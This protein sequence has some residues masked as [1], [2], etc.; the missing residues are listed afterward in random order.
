MSGIDFLAWRL[1]YQSDEHALRAAFASVNNLA[2]QLERA[3]AQLLAIATAKRSNFEDSVEYQDWAAS[4]AA[5]ALADLTGAAPAPG[6][7]RSPGVCLGCRKKQDE[8]HE[9]GCFFEPFV[10]GVKS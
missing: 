1:T 10:F 2:G 9:Q 6:I 4:K 3:K 7:T 8:P 5:R